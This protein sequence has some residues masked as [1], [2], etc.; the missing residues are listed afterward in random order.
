MR[1]VPLSAPR[2]ASN[3]G[4]EPLPGIGIHNL[5]AIL[6]AP[7]PSAGLSEG[8]RASP[9]DGETGLSRR[10]RPIPKRTCFAASHFWEAL[11]SLTWSVRRMENTL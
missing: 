1:G 11:K 4:A 8:L 3:P 6:K 9:A 7:F 2:C 10:S 5:K